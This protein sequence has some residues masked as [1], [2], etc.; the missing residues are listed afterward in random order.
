[1]NS[2][3]IDLRYIL[4]RNR[5]YLNEIQSQIIDYINR[6][7]YQSAIYKKI[8]RLKELKDYEELKYKTNFIDVVSDTR[9][10]MFQR[11]SLLKSRV[12]LDLLYSD[13]GHAIARKL[14]NKLHLLRY[15]GRQPAGKM[16]DGF[17]ESMR[18][19]S[20]SLN[21]E[22]LVEKFM[23]SDSDL[24]QFVMNYK[25]PPKV[26]MLTLEKRISMYV[27]ISIDYDSKLTIS[28]KLGK[29]DYVNEKKQKLKLGYAIIKPNRKVVK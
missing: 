13:R 16:V 14:A 23:T 6:I 28:G 12:S 5:D 21:I 19:E 1:L 22:G 18:E 20:T 24:F 15:S 25:F 29:M 2:I 9:A 27:G 8:Q 26:G 4:V 10:L 17:D 7:Q 3:V 11:R